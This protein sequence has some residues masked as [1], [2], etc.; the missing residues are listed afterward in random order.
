MD[1]PYRDAERRAEEWAEHR[2]ASDAYEPVYADGTPKYECW[3]SS[4]AAVP[5]P[6]PESDPQEGDRP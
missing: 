4:R 2:A 5:K 6:R 1:R 3:N